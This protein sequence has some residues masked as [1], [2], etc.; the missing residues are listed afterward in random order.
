[1]IRSLQVHQFRS[2]S[3]E[4]MAF[5]KGMSAIIGPNGIGKTN[6]LEAIAFT[7]LGRSFR[8]DT[9]KDLI[10]ENEADSRLLLTFDENG[11]EHRI[12]YTFGKQGKEILYN[13]TSLKSFSPLLGQIPVGIVCPKDVILIEGAPLARRKYLNQI[14]C[15]SSKEYTFH[16]K[17]LIDTIEQ[18]NAALKAEAFNTLDIFDQILYTSATFIQTKRGE[19][20]DSLN[21]LLVPEKEALLDAGETISLHYLPSIFEPSSSTRAKEIERRTSLFGPQRDDFK[22][23]LNG[24]DAACHASEGQKRTMVLALRFA[25]LMALKDSTGKSPLLLID[26]FGAHLDNKRSFRLIQRTKL[27]EQCILTAPHAPEGVDHIF[28]LELCVK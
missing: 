20:I 9:I 23:E 7:T 27:I 8:T 11:V 3:Y 21:A 4:K 12:Q 2:H 18:K 17:R 26:D 10:R 5:S 22:I 25:E 24:K 1:M 16:L 14:L 13:D 6:L 15:Q 28:D 19:L